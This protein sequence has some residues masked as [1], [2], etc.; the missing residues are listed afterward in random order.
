M[1]M[2]MATALYWHDRFWHSG[3]ENTPVV[4]TLFFLIIITWFSLIVNE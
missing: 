1:D 4:Y 2:P 3:N